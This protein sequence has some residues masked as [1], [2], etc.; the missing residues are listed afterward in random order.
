MSSFTVADLAAYRDYAEKNSGEI[1]SKMLFGFKT[2]SIATGHEGVKGR[3]N[4]TELTIQDLSTRYSE[5]FTPVTDAVGL[6]PRF[7]DVYDAKIDLKFVPKRWERTYQGHLRKTGQ[8]PMDFPLMAFIF[9]KIIEKHQNERELAAWQGVP[10]AVPAS[11]DKLIAVVK[12]FHK[13][14]TDEI[15]ATNITPVVTGAITSTNAVSLI[16]GMYEGL[17]SS[18]QSESIDVFMSTKGR[19]RLLQDYRERYGKYTRDKHGNPQLDIGTGNDRFNICPGMKE[20][21]ILIT[22]RANTHYGYDLETDATSFNLEQ[23]DRSLKAWLDYKIGFNFGI[24]NDDIIAA[25]D[26]H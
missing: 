4:L 25:N 9:M 3:V 20:N 16:E 11:T 26:Q 15:T 1:L 14:V 22:P 17:G 10:A 19:I 18:Y 24:V 12:G 23:E 7:L 5:I 8:D 13:I 21:A 2:G 6:S